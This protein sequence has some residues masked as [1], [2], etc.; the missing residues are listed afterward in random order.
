MIFVSHSANWHGD[1]DPIR[2]GHQGSKQMSDTDFKEMASFDTGTDDL[3]AWGEAMPGVEE[4]V[5]EEGNTR[6]L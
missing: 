2:W 6:I 5:D 3:S 4:A 1:S